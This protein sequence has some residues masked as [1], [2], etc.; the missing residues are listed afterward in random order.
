MSF[1]GTANTAND[2]ISQK[3]MV[4]GSD[5]R[6]DGNYNELKKLQNTIQSNPTLYSGFLEDAYN[7]ISRN[8]LIELLMEKYNTSPTVTQLIVANQYNNDVINIDLLNLDNNLSEKDTEKYILDKIIETQGQISQQS[9]ENQFSQMN[10][11]AKLKNNLSTEELQQIFNDVQEQEKKD[12]RN[13]TIAEFLR[14]LLD[15]LFYF[16]IDVLANGENIVTAA[17]KD[18]RALFIGLDIIILLIFMKTFIL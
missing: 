2:F 12:F 7:D 3:Q 4:V 9:F 11:V 6:F 8:K 18:N 17:L 10:D 16:L 15:S 14:K 13:L 5:I 1:T